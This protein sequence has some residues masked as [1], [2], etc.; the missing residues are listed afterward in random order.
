MRNTGIN[1]IY[2]FILIVNYIFNTYLYMIFF[3]HINKY[4]QLYLYVG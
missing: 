3:Q 2:L 1:S 4:T